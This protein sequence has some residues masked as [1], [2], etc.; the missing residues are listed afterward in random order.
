MA[1]TILPTL[2]LQNSAW[3]RNPARAAQFCPLLNTCL[4]HSSCPP[5]KDKT[6]IGFAKAAHTFA[7]TTH[8][9]CRLA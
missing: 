2:L 3:T 1:A 5:I 9:T 6:K 4:L 7:A 8:N